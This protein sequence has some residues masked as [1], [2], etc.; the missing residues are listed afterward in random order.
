MRFVLAPLLFIMMV[1]VPIVAPNAPLVFAVFFFRQ[2]LSLLVAR[3]LLASGFG[4]A[5]TYRMWRLWSFDLVRD[6]GP[7]LDYVMTT[8]VPYAAAFAVAGWVLAALITPNPE[9]RTGTQ[10]PRTQNREPKSV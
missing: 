4:L 3:F 8:I 7:S 6:S 2:R 1:V 5:A 10:N 9:P